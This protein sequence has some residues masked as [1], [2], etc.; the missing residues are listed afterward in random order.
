MIRNYKVLFIALFLAVLSGC[1]GDLDVEPVDPNLVSSANAYETTAD[2]KKGL[3]KLYLSFAMSGQQGGDELPDFQN[4][5]AGASNYLRQYWN[6]Q[7]LTTDEAVIS[8]NDLTVK[9]LHWHTWTATDTYIGLMYS[10][11]FYTVALCNEFIRASAGSDNADVQ[12]FRAEARLLR[13]LAYSHAI[14]M[15]GNPSFVTEANLPGAYFPEQIQRADLFTYIESELLDIEDD[16]GEPKFEYGRADKAVA[17]MVLS[18]LYLNAEVYTGEKRSTDCITW[19]NKILAGPYSISEEYMHN[20]VA[21]NN[22]S[23]ELIFPIAYDGVNTRTYGG[24]TYILLSQIGGSMSSKDMFGVGQAWAGLRTTSALVEKFDLEADT[25]ALFW[26]DGQSLEIND[27]GVFSDGYAITKFRNLKLDGSPSDSNQELFVDTDWPMFRL[28]DAY[29]MYAEAVLRDGAGGS[30]A[31][32]LSYVNEL[33]ERA[34][35]DV[36]GNISA[37][38][39]TLD[40]IL[41]ER[42]RELFWEGHRRTDLIRFGKFTGGDYVWPWKGKVQEGKAT[43]AHYNLFPIPASER[44]ANPNLV[45]NDDY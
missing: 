29:L 40:F 12:T 2:Y 23:P 17:W 14:D 33:R 36:S 35:G 25:R 11:I 24:M 7:E 43:S 42:A 45:Q 9:D 32:A 4:T 41:E 18:K 39:L 13:A 37:D 5:D 27:I 22:T 28:A 38:E 21:D 8:W 6:C 1:V 26:T 15:F 31:T 3:A 30:S 20:F 44:G 16:L 34:F 10:R 19:L